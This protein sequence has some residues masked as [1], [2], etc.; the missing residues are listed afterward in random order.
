MIKFQIVNAPHI[1]YNQTQFKHPV[2]ATTHSA[3]YDFYSPIDIT[4][5]PKSTAMIWTNFKAQ[6][7]HN[8]VLIL[9]VTS[10]MGKRGVML[11]NTIGVI[12]SDYYGNINN[13]GNIGIALYNYS[14]NPYTIHTG[15]KIGQGIFL[16]F[17]TADDEATID[18]VRV[19]GFGSTD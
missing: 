13:D 5:Q 17:L 14:D 10:G 15:D 6:F 19:G 3:G 16:P 18:N 12:D 7:D 4:I 11:A 1:Q 8:I 2:R 9:S